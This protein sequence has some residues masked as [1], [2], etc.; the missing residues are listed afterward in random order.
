MRRWL[1]LGAAVVVEVAAT[2]ALKAS[3]DDPRWL[4]LVISGYCGSFVLLAVCLRLGL[5]IGVTYGLWG[6]AGVVLTA[7]LSA[8]IFAEALTPLMVV[9]IALIVAGVLVVELGSQRAR[10]SGKALSQGSGEAA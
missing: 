2:L 3:L 10:A 1:A 7:L 4:V 9:G 6:A 5:P 8:L